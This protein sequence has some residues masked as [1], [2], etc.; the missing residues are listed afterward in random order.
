MNR[1]KMQ[2]SAIDSF[3]ST[4]FRCLNDD[5]LDPHKTQHFDAD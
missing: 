1:I 2:I 4:L 5:E 3:I